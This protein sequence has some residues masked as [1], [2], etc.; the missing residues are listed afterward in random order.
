MTNFIPSVVEKHADEVPILLHMRDQY[1]Q[2]ASTVP[3]DL[4]A[5]DKRLAANLEGLALAGKGGWDAAILQFENRPEPATIMSVAYLAYH[6]QCRS[7]L[8]YV[9]AALRN[10]DTLVEMAAFGLSW[11]GPKETARIV[12]NLWAQGGDL[13]IAT[14]LACA[15]IYEMPPA[16]RDIE[17]CLTGGKVMRAWAIEVAGWYN[18]RTLSDQLQEKQQDDDPACCAA[19]DA[20]MILLTADQAAVQRVLKRCE[21]GLDAKDKLLKLALCGADANIGSDWWHRQGDPELRM[22]ASGILSDKRCVTWLLDQC[23]DPVFAEEAMDRIYQITGRQVWGI[24]AEPDLEK[25]PDPFVVD[26]K[27]QQSPAHQIRNWW[28]NEYANLIEGPLF[29]GQRMDQAQSKAGRG[30]PTLA[31][32]RQ[33]ALRNRFCSK[34]TAFPLGQAPCLNGPMR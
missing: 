17:E 30:Q 10:D 3:S 20:A 27:E 13:D 31:V 24:L 1:L 16:V 34:T 19:R 8:E 23:D 12:Q 2:S 15:L 9:G 26:V 14:A 6:D 7:R 4:R 33:I 32:H 18:M 25:A 11:L 5:L 21:N 29:E 28:A 22:K